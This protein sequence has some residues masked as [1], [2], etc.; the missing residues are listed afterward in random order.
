MKFHFIPYIDI[1][2]N[3]ENTK[4]SPNS[5][6]QKNDKFGK[7]TWLNKKTM[8]FRNGTGLGVW[9]SKRSLST[10][11]THCKC[12]METSHKSVKGRVR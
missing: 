2:Q 4:G 7:R 8:Q 5:I 9:R 11:H 6:V 12:S 10:C 3:R 1:K